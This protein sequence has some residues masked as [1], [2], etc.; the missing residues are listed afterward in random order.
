MNPDVE[1]IAA[2]KPGLLTAHGP[3]VVASSPYAKRGVLWSNYRRHYGA[4]GDPSVLVARGSS[5][6]FNPTIDAA[7]IER[8]LE[9]DRPRN[10]AEYLAEFRSDLEAYVSLDAVEACVTSGVRER[11]ALRNVAYAAF[12]DPSGGSVDS[13]PH[14]ESFIRSPRRRSRA[15]PAAPRCRALLPFA[16]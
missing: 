6:D 12:V 11:G 2:I 14:C 3:L 7:E 15:G 13:L 9:E 5:R 16:G 8:L 10:T 1:I 4:D